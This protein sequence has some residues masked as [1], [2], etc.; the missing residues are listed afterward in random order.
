MIYKPVIEVVGISTEITKCHNWITSL[1]RV[2]IWKAVPSL[3]TIIDDIIYYIQT[4]KMRIRNCT[5]GRKVGW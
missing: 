4:T 5:S 3:W 1:A 2:G